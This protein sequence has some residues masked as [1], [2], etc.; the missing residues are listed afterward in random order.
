MHAIGLGGES[1]VDAI[2]DDERHA[3]RRQRRFDR[4]RLLDHG[5][6]LADLVAQLDE[7][8]A[9]L[10]AKPRQIGEIVPAGA[11]RIDDGVEAKINRHHKTPVIGRTL[12]RPPRLV[13][14]SRFG[15]SLRRGSRR[16]V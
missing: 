13:Q 8:G 3:K 7:R 9:A 6:R 15:I 10:G 14:S 4:P 12:H 11:L 16:R 1:D 5:A 2:V